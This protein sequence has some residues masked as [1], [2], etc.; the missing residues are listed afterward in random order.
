MDTEKQ[1]LPADEAANEEAVNA[2]AQKEA[3]EDNSPLPP[4]FR[5]PRAMGNRP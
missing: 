5:C 3:T 4:P 2:E 1:T